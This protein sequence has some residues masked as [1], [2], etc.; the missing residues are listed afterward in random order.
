[1]YTIKVENLTFAYEET[2]E[3]HVL[4]NMSFVVEKGSITALT[5]LSGCGKSTVCRILTGIIP[6]CM[7][8]KIEGRI[9]IDGI[10]IKELEMCE[11]SQ[12]MGFVMQD[13]DRQ[14]VA[15]TVEDELAFGPEN[16][17]MAPDDIRIIVDK[18]M[19]LLKISHLAEESPN[20]LSGGQ[21]Q[22]V[23]I[24]SV[25][26]MNPKILVMDEPFSHLDEEGKGIMK[27]TLLKLKNA[28]KTIVIVDHDYNALDF[29][30]KILWMEEGKII[31]HKSR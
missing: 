9:T 25:L 23:A 4:E 6:K 31:E 22:L 16:L 13:A 18:V 20:K 7:D 17:C 11:I 24:G 15:A 21:K 29:V 5:G 1:M 28:G 3:R 26:T 27:K 30:D 19:N 12:R 2:S 8:G 14:I 10:D